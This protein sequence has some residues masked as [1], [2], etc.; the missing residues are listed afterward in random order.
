M[1]FVFHSWTTV[2]WHYWNFEEN[3]DRGFLS[4]SHLYYQP[5]IASYFHISYICKAHFLKSQ[6]ELLKLYLIIFFIYKEL[7][8]HTKS[9][10]LTKLKCLR[11]SLVNPTVQIEWKTSTMVAVVCGGECFP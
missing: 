5:S 6:K 11:N 8:V 10:H 4:V 3:W 9:C 7:K 2:R 1:F